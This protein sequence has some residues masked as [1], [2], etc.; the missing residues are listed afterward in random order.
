MSRRWKASWSARTR[1]AR[2]KTV[3][4]EETIIA[5]STHTAAQRS[6]KAAERNAN[7]KIGA[8]TLHLE[9]LG[10]IRKAPKAPKVCRDCGEESPKLDRLGTCANCLRKMAVEDETHPSFSQR[11]EDESVFQAGVSR[12]ISNIERR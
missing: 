4:G 9:D 11:S 3:T 1:G 12:E 7:A 2:W 10:A 8:I 5:S 6:I